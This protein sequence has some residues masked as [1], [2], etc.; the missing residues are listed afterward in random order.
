MPRDLRLLVVD[1]DFR[2]AA[3][4][5]SVVDSMVGLVTVGSART[6]AEATAIVAR[7]DAA[8]AP[9][10]LALVD[11]YLPDG[12]GI[13][14]VRTGPSDFYVLEDNCRVPS[15]VSYML[16]NREAMLRLLPQL[17]A[18]H[19]IQPVSHYPEELLET[20][21]SVAPA[22]CRAVPRVAILTPGSYNSPFT[23]STLSGRNAAGSR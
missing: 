3:L 16:E 22:N 10:D 20:L 18:A 11:V 15:G 7:A 23:P 12:S 21:K 2:V 9:V 13:D 5:A 8:Q 4:H 14:L 17:C 19:R 1:D 6:V